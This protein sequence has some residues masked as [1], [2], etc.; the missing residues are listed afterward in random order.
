[1]QVS[2]MIYFVQLHQ[3][4]FDLTISQ[5]HITLEIHMQLRYF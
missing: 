2:L 3:K 1:M 4:H 5:Y